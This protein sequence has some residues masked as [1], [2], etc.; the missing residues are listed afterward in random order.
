VSRVNL[1][2]QTNSIAP[3]RHLQQGGE[4]AIGNRP[5][6]AAIDPESPIR[7]WNSEDIEDVARIGVIVGKF[8]NAEPFYSDVSFQ[9]VITSRLK[10]REPSFGAVGRL[11]YLMDSL[12]VKHR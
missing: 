11:K 12:M 4:Q 3:T 7:C 1:W 6:R 9:E 10:R 2:G 5:E 8:L